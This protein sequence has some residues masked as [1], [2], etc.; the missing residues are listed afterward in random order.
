MKGRL[1]TDGT[2]WLVNFRDSENSGYIY[3]L[4]R[5]YEIPTPYM[6]SI[7]RERVVELLRN[8]GTEIVA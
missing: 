4:F 1:V 5:T 7:P 8:A 3:W 6:V 2:Q